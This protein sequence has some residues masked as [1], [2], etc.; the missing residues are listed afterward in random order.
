MFSSTRLGD[1]GY[2]YTSILQKPAKTPNFKANSV[3]NLTRDSF[4]VRTACTFA[5]TGQIKSDAIKAAGK[6]LLSPLVIMNN[7]LIKEDK[8]S[9]RYSAAMQPIEAGI[10]F[11]ASILVNLTAAVFINK[12][13][14][15]GALGDMYKVTGK[16]GKAL[17]DSQKNLGIFKDRVFVGIT[18]L[19]IPITSTI[20]N[21]TYP[22][23]L[24]FIFAQ[25]EKDKLKKFWEMPY[26]TSLN[27]QSGNKVLNRKI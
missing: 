27:N 13:A 8:E 1:R 22:K 11:L 21:K 2:Y 5:E 18:L 15:R 25:E 3:M 17:L 26:A 19:T 7:P 9:R 12:L 6:A 4:L 16:A 23:I 20:L 24:K 10:S 14:A